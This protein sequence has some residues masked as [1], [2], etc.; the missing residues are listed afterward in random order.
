MLRT[1]VTGIF[2][3]FLV[4]TAW[5]EEFAIVVESAAGGQNAEWFSVVEGNWM[6]SASKSKAPGLQAPKAMF[7]TAGTAG[8]ARFTPDIP[9]EGEYEVF[10]T[11]PDSGNAVGVIYHIHSASGDS[12][13]VIDQ[14][15]RDD[16]AKPRA[17]TWFSLGKFKFSKGKH[18]Y[19]E[20]RDPQTGKA[21][22]EKEPNIRIYADAVKFVPVGFTLPPQFAVKASPSKEDRPAV[23]GLPAAPM[24]EAAPQ[25]PLPQP[26]VSSSMP[27]LSGSSQAGANL[28]SAGSAS[29]PPL[30]ASAGQQAATPSLPALGS[31]AASS[32]VGPASQSMPALPPAQGAEINVPPPQPAG[33]PQLP[34]LG[35]AA[36]SST[37]PSGSVPAL[38][39]LPSGEMPSPASAAST[40]APVQTPALEPLT[41]TNSQAPVLAS[42]VP[43]PTPSAGTAPNM[44]GLAPLAPNVA[45]PSQQSPALTPSAP[46]SP[47]GL[48]WIYD[49]GSAHAAARTQNKKVLVYF[50]AD[51]N[52]ICQK[53]ESEYF[54]N[55]AVR[56]VMNQ[57]VLRKVN[58]ALNTKAA[59][60]AKVYGAGSI[61]IT[62]A[63]GEAVGT[64]VE[65]PATPE[66]FAQKLKELAAK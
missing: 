12:E 10:T 56:E 33:A 8:A 13:V 39:A 28:P 58:F 54:Q 22:N 25:L 23:A 34:V 60:K 35:A 4:T 26:T 6:E 48:L 15:G 42:P 36:P 3:F 27:P 62:D 64:I 61:A 46:S 17:N 66:E 63:F 30:A 19:V 40:A 9:V 52:R 1:L 55:P 18:G 50:V 24:P 5:S 43:S 14:R 49:E 37:P 53:Y 59:Y 31:L 11:Y 7:K 57:F 44:A 2:S 29:L 47:D 21:A 16:R 65:I 32:P 38:P 41:P 45:Q 20:I 51:G